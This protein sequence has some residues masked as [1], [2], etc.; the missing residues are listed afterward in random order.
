MSYQPGFPTPASGQHVP[1][2]RRLASVL[3]SLPPRPTSRPP[4]VEQVDEVL[5]DGLPEEAEEPAGYGPDPDYMP[6]SIEPAPTAPLPE[7]PQEREPDH[8]P[9]WQG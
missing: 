8:D 6:E 1:S 7:D 4:G 3:A 9:S 5:P 2:G